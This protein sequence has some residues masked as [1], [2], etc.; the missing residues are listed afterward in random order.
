LVCLLLS[1]AQLT[2]RFVLV[3]VGLASLFAWLGWF[4]WLIGGLVSWLVGLIAFGSW[5]ADWW[6]L[7]A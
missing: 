3:W 6:A 1:V 4:G 5:P 2:V 7:L